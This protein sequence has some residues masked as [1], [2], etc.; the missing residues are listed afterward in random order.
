VQTVPLV[1]AGEGYWGE[2]KYQDMETT[3]VSYDPKE[4][5]SAPLAIAASAEKG[6]MPD[7]SVDVETARMIVTG[8]ADFLTNEALNPTNVDF[9]VAG[10]NWLLNR[11]DLI[12]IPPKP[13]QQFTLNLTDLQMQRM[14]VLVLLV[15]P[16]AVAMVGAFVWAQ[17]RR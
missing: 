13:E 7:Q 11:K 4:D 3:G 8:N 9:V 12:G 15:M 5:I 2:T 6:A 10:L 16:S 14:E 1:T 17:R